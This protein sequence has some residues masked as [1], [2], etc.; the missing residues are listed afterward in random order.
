MDQQAFAGL[1]L[2]FI[3]PWLVLL[4]LLVLSVAVM[5]FTITANLM[6]AVS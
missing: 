3:Y 2:G 4:P 1:A 6:F 5:L